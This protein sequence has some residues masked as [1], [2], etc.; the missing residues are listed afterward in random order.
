MKIYFLS[1]LP[2]A[3]TVNGAYFGVTDTFAR[4]AEVDLRDRVF[5]QFT[6]QAAHPVGFFLTESLTET[7]PDGCEV[8]LL[9]NAIAV[10]VYDFT[11]LDQTL[12]PILQKRK[13]DCLVTVFQQGKT[14]V[15]I[16]SPNGFFIAT[17]PPSFTPFDVSFHAGLCFVEGENKLAVYTQKGECALSETVLRFSVEN[18]E[19]HASLPLSDSLGRIADC[20]WKLS[21]DGCARTNVVLRQRNAAD[22]NRETEKIADELLPYAF[23][24]S[25]LLGT[26]IRLFLAD[27][28]QAEAE[29]LTAFL[30]EFREVVPTEETDVCGLVRDVAPRLYRVDYYRAKTENRKIV[31]VTELY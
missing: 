22:G 25:V 24:E 28:L 27:E 16:E 5:V 20:V 21:S 15:S 17:L 8:Y 14:Q 18:D 29:R 12:R 23:F 31:D 13:D 6:P 4:A 3:L 19:L 7:P 26:D 11:P 2:C 1:A 10:C 9:K 30:G